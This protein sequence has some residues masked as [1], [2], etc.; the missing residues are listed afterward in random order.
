MRGARNAIAQSNNPK[1]HIPRESH[2]MED[3]VDLGNW[4]SDDENQECSEYDSDEEIRR[5]KRYRRRLH[6]KRKARE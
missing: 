3:M 4:H 6:L 1:S 2:F 5:L